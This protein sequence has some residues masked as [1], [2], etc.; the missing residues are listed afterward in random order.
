MKK[1]LVTGS[2]GLLGQKLVHAMINGDQ[3][4]CIATSVG[5]NRIKE[6]KGYSYQELDI[7]N[8]HDVLQMIAEIKPDTVINTAAMTNVDACES[9]K[10]GCDRLNVDA[11]RYL[12]EACEENDVH[13]IH[14]STDFVF[15]GEDGPYA[16]E[17]RPN[18]LSYYGNSKFK[19][20]EIVKNSGLKSWSIARTIIVYGLVD[21]MSR[22]NLV[23][24]AKG[25]LEKGDPIKVV[26][27]QFRSPTLAQD[28]AAGC[29]LIAEKE[30]SGIFHLSGPESMSILEAVEKIGAFYGLST[31]N[32]APIKSESLGQDAKRPPRTG[33]ILDKAKAE[34]GYQP[35][36]FVRGLEILT[37]EL[38]ERSDNS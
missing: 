26:D 34:L 10:E 6:K 8:R 28:L 13:L 18:P 2:N 15:D 38:Q 3:F 14:L 22:S 7:T 4:E 16:E 27:D 29:L 25:A 12:V 5:P 36:S 1:I 32:V 20:E 30:T 21:E 37:A 33:F 19:S 9:D 35:C 24:W 17:D 23:L 31:E 11:V